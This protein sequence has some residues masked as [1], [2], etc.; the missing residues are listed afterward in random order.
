MLAPPGLGLGLDEGTRFD[1]ILEEA[2]VPLSPGDFFL[3][4]TDGLS[5]AGGWDFEI[6]NVPAMW[7]SSAVALLNYLI[8]DNCPGCDLHPIDAHIGEHMQMDDTTVI[9]LEKTRKGDREVEIVVPSLAMFRSRV[10]VL[11]DDIIST[12]R[13]M[14]KAVG[15]IRAAGAYGQVMAKEKGYAQIKLPSG[16]VRMVLDRC[17]ATVGCTH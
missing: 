17:R 11:V 1:R 6:R 15:L 14:T 4:F 13:T 8:G 3:F 9:V 2:E 10:P 7:V 12:A 5:E 16:E